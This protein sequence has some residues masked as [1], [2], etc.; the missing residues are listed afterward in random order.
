VIA[1][2]ALALEVT[3]D[4]LIGLKAKNGDKQ[5][6]TKVLRRVK[7][8]EVLPL[9]QQKFILKAIDSHLKA[10]EKIKQQA[11]FKEEMTV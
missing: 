3:V 2:F 8:I 11:P 9:A 4:E 7:K 5:Q 10:L 1:R 6:S